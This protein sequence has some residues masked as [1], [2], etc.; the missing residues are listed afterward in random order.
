MVFIGIGQILIDANKRRNI[1][2]EMK[3]KYRHIMAITIG[4]AIIGA[5][6]LALW[7]LKMVYY[8]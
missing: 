6:F 5:Y 3:L 7:I 1:H 4:L 2:K 8:A